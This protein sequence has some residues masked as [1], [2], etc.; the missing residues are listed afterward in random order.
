MIA[1]W[2]VAGAMLAAASPVAAQAPDAARAAA[3]AELAAVL[4]VRGQ[5]RR[6]MVKQMD[7]MRSGRLML[8]QLDRDPR[9]RMARSKNPQQ[10]ETVFKRIGTLQAGAAERAL[11]E[12]EPEAVRATAAAYAKNFTA[13][14]LRQL[15]AFYQTPIGR[16][17]RERLPRI[18]QETTG[19][20]TARLGPRIA[21]EQR[22]I[23]PQ[24]QAELRRLAPAT[25]ATPSGTP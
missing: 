14:E 15:I 21:E 25:P 23:A 12:A 8:R 4:D 20:M 16:A 13:A 7:D 10:F 9:F 19:A 11:T 17:L 6:S 22:R 18:T 5:L 3:A 1:R 2:L 24:I